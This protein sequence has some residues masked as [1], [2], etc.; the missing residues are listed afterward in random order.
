M[1]KSQ[2]MGKKVHLQRLVAVKSS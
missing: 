1:T 2:L